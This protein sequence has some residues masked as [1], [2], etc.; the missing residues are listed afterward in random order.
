LKALYKYAL[1][2]DSDGEPINLA[3]EEFVRRL[4][5]SK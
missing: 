2:D 1:F 5:S 4:E 3:G